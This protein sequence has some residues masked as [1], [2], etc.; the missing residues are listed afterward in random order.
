MHDQ[1]PGQRPLVAGQDHRAR[2]SQTGPM[3]GQDAPDARSSNVLTHAYTTGATIGLH[4][5][6]VDRDCLGVSGTYSRYTAGPG[7][8]AGGLCSLS[9][10]MVS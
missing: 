5:F 1:P 6:A 2:P 7:R 8:P 4:C 10:E 9:N 3:P